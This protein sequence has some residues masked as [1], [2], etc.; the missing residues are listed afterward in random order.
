MKINPNKYT[1]L[2]G[3]KAVVVVKKINDDTPLTENLFS[4]PLD[5]AIANVD[6]PFITYGLPKNLKK[7]I[8]KNAKNIIPLIKKTK[9]PKYTALVQSPITGMLIDVFNTKEKVK[10]WFSDGIYVMTL[11]EANE[12]RKYFISDFF[13]MDSEVNKIINE[14]KD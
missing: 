9:Y 5:F 4:V 8:E 10:K 6:K 2:I 3:K 12:Y 14:L 1:A 7:Y 13:S 11:E